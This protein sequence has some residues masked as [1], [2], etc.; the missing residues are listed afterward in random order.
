M[1]WGE[2]GSETLEDRMATSL[3]GLAE[4]FVNL[5]SEGQ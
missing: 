3:T 5:E 4:G 2:V 1:G